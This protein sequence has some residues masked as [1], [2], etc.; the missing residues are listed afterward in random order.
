[1]VIVT[2]SGVLFSYNLPFFRIYCLKVGLDLQESL[3]FVTNNSL[4]GIFST[5]NGGPGSG[6]SDHYHHGMLH[7]LFI[8]SVFRSSPLQKEC[9]AKKIKGYNK[10]GV[11]QVQ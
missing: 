7:S 2:F 10:G 5:E 6:R 11:S 4:T 9:E 8:F 1:M 3:N